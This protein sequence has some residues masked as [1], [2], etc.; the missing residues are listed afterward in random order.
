MVVIG[1]RWYL[2]ATVKKTILLSINISQF[3]YNWLGAPWLTQKWM[4][5]C[6]DAYQNLVEGLVGNDDNGYWYLTMGSL[7]IFC[8]A[9]S[10]CRFGRTFGLY[11]KS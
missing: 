4:Y 2:R 10:Y 8:R 5:I 11:F 7:A 6:A 9:Y 1:N 3:L